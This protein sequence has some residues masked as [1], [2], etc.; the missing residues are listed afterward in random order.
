MFEGWRSRRGVLLVVR[1]Q[2]T[3]VMESVR[4]LMIKVYKGLDLVMSLGGGLKADV[5]SDRL[6]NF[7][8]VQSEWR[9]LVILGSVVG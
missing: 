6:I 2:L 9:A 3:G 1:A 5:T 4:D 7:G 8:S